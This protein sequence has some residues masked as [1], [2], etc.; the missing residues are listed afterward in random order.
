MTQAVFLYNKSNTYGL[1][2]DVKVFEDIL[3]QASRQANLGFN[4]VRI[5]DPLEPP[6]LCDIAFHFEVPIYAYFPWARKNALIINPEWYESV[7]DPY[8]EHLDYLIFK[9]AKDRDY[10]MDAH[11]ECK[12]QPFL[13][14]WTTPV[15]PKDF[16]KLPKSTDHS[17][18]CLWLL[19]ASQNKRAAAEALLPYWKA[20]WPKLDVYTTTPLTKNTFAENVTVHVKDLPEQTR[21]TLQ[22]FYPC[23]LI[24]SKAEAL[25][26]AAQEGQ[27]AGAFLLGNGLPVYN[28][29]FG[30]PNSYENCSLVGISGKPL[31]AGTCDTFE[32]LQQITYN[33]LAQQIHGVSQQDGYYIQGIERGIQKFLKRNLDECRAQQQKVAEDRYQAFIQNT[34]PL[35]QSIK[36]TPGKELKVLPP[37]LSDEYCPPI[38]VVTLLYNR[39]KFVDLAF[40]NLLIT[41]YPKNKIEWI[42]VDDSDIQEEQASDK[43]MKFGRECAPMNLT[44]IPLQKKTS[45]GEKRNMA[46]KRALHDI[47]VMMDDDDHYPPT[48][49]RRRVAWLLKHPMNPNAV[50]TT[51][52]ACYDLL[53][54]TSAVNTPPW[55]LPLSQRVSEATLAFKKSFW[56]EKPFPDT[57]M[58]EGEGFLLDREEQLLELQPQQIIVAMSHNKNASSRRIP[59]GPSG[60][61]SCFWGFPKEFLVFLH[62]LAGVAIEEDKS[63][64]SKSK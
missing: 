61:P 40:H 21:R 60:Q 24:F 25:G 12:A 4:K 51:T 9:C 26:M 31:K 52:I 29:C 43:I 44:Y 17:T 35:L 13:L 27:A 58:A 59:S 20:E 38:S 28:E 41:D 7:W 53:K 16:A 15:R 18:G 32:H 1:A 55:N 54:G 14:P 22:A 2:E 23:H 34:I 49:F 48:S 37:V 45:I 62:G 64:P 46:C 33:G 11:P 30:H 42:V 63:K 57:N 36:Q 5:S 6:I 56:N 39:R 19:G 47:V 10:F 8:L 50:A 3:K